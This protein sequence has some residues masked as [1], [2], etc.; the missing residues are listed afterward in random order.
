MTHSVYTR[1]YNTIVEPILLYGGGVWGFKNFRCVSAVQNRACKFFLNVGKYSSNLSSRGDMGW[2]SCKIKLQKSCLRLLCKLH[3][4]ED[5]RIPKK[6]FQWTSRRR[7]GWTFEINRLV[8]KL[9]IRELVSDVSLSTKHVMNSISE[10][11]DIMD[12]REW[13]DDVFNDRGKANGNKLRTYRLYKQS[14]SVEPY[15]KLNIDRNQRRYMAMFRA[16]SLPLALETGRYS[17]PPVPVE[18]RLCRYCDLGLVETEK[19]FL[20][21]CPLY[22]DLRFDLFHQC[23]NFIE[24]FDFMTEDDKFI[25]I[26]RCENIQ[27][28]LCKSLQ[29]FFLRRKFFTVDDR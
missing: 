15:V 25:E 1:L 29:K 13:L 22:S 27:E 19:H 24:N 3:R 14:V 18:N 16:G 8:D 26:F 23:S 11:L 10:K 4:L 17:R 2:T 9:E 7:K 12:N 6:V 5:N 21:K 20:M 28:F